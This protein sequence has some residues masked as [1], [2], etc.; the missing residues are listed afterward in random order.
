MNH[1]LS[2]SSSRILSICFSRTHTLTL[3]EVTQTGHDPL[4]LQ[5]RNS[6]R[7]KTPSVSNQEQLLPGKSAAHE[8]NYELQQ[9]RAHLDATLFHK[10]PLK[11]K[12]SARAVCRCNAAHVPWGFSSLSA[13]LPPSLNLYPPKGLGLAS[14]LLLIYPLPS[15]FPSF[16]FFPPSEL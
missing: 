12:E 11:L 1:Q 2:A 6:A 3:K 10:A 4:V 5:G 14:Q 13:I 7:T 16:F 8:I 9:D 15:L